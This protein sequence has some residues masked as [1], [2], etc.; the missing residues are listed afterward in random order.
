MRDGPAQAGDSGGA[1]GWGTAASAA[2]A[3]EAEGRA[4][5]GPLGAPVVAVCLDVGAE[6]GPLCAAPGRGLEKEL[7]AG[8]PPGAGVAA[9]GPEGRGL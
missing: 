8:V 3:P 7:G 5:A 2:S 4:E 1:A 9:G 6:A